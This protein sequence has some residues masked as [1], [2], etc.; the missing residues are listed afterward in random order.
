MSKKDEE[1]KNQPE[2]QK[3]GTVAVH[4]PTTGAVMAP[5]YMN[6]EDFG[7][8]FE[9]A[10]KDSFAIPFLQVLQKM[11]PLVD[12]DNTAHIPGA[13]AGMLYNTV[14][15]KLYDG[16]AGLEAVQAAY[17]RSFILWGGRE[18]DGGFK[19]EFTVEEVEKMKDAGDIL[20]HEGRYYAP[21]ADGSFHE[22]KNDYYADTR[23]HFL[24]VKDP[25]TGETGRAIFAL[26]STQIKASRALMTSL[27][28]KKVEVPGR[29]KMTPPTFANVLKITTVG[30]TNDKGSWSGAVIQ[31]NG[32]T[33]KETYEEARDFHKA[34]TSGEV[35]ADHA[36][37]AQETTGNGGEAAPQADEF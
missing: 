31:L 33:D 16:K 32:M 34:I 8:G 23:S 1:K 37:S 18:A 11:S 27:Q 28:Q 5:E 26:T 15:Q 25:E 20:V 30:Q 7:G 4:T 19:G 10:D 36:K 9:G 24:I 29:G 3:G 2:E 6:A 22:K 21:N 12:E 13:K 17:R 35:K 14:T